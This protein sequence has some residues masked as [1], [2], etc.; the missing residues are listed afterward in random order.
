MKSLFLTIVCVLVLTSCYDQ[1]SYNRVASDYLYNSYEVSSNDTVFRKG[2]VKYT[3]K[4]FGGFIIDVPET[5]KYL[6]KKEISPQQFREILE[7]ES[8]LNRF[9]QW[10]VKR[11]LNKDFDRISKKNEKHK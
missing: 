4:F 10:R 5:E 3:F 6:D 7:G 1:Q 8:D 11:L 9:T 2:F